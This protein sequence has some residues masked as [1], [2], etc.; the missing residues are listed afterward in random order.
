[1]KHNRRIS[2]GAILVLCSAFLTTHA[3]NRPSVE[4]HP[5]PA[6]DSIR[7][8]EA[9]NRRIL[10]KENEPKERI[11][12]QV[13]EK[14]NLGDSTFYERIFE[15]HYRD[16]NTLER[17]KYMASINI[18]MPGRKHR[19]PNRSRRFNPHWSGLGMGIAYLTG[20]DSRNIPLKSIHSFDFN[21]HL[22]E[23]AVPITPRYRW[24]FVTGFGLRW[25]RYHLKG[26][27]H[28]EESDDYTHLVE[29]Q[30][31]RYKKSR[32]G[33]TSYSIPLLLEWQEPSG[34]RLFFSFGAIGTVTPWS[35][36]KI[37]YYDEYGRKR[38]QTIAKEMTLRPLNI[39][40]FAQIGLHHWSIFARYTPLSLF[41]PHKGPELY[42]LSIGMYNF[43]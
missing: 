5:H 27:R 3:A 19:D 18:P 22:L 12:V 11:D 40:L 26:N 13:Y 2:T 42:P 33:S 9:G 36:S 6:G 38:H 15:G 24:A 1:M 30:G 41:R 17:R 21:F 7:I 4:D 43:F 29:V 35:S 37:V 16:G 28:F 34:S 31:V 10:L 8:F 39:D 32:L 23:V 25:Q 20:P 14:N